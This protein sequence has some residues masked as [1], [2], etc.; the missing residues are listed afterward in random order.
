M[1]VS[2]DKEPLKRHMECVL[3]WKVNITALLCAVLWRRKQC[4]IM[5]GG[6]GTEQT[7]I[8]NFWNSFFSNLE[9]DPDSDYALCYL[10]TTNSLLTMVP[11][12][13]FLT[14]IATSQ[15]IASAFLFVPRVDPT[16]RNWI[17]KPKVSQQQY[18]YVNMTEHKKKLRYH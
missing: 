10:P 9:E 11:R 17:N 15:W 14:F 1:H 12:I 7:V 6:C 4:Q 18:F 16:A 2:S 13:S 5:L 8:L 3:R